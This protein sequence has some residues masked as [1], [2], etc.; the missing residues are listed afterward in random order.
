MYSGYSSFAVNAC[1]CWGWGG[2]SWKETAPFV[3]GSSS[4]RL[5]LRGQEGRE[6]LLTQ[7]HSL[8]HPESNLDL[9]ITFLPSSEYVYQ[10][11]ILG[12]PKRCVEYVRI[13][14]R[15]KHVFLCCNASYCNSWSVKDQVPFNPLPPEKP[16]FS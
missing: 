14:N 10:Y 16:D 7:P 13:T 4:L 9:A 6:G 8:S 12:C 2:S 1:G 3:E 5:C 15:N 11:S